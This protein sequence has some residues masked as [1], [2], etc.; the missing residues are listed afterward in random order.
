MVEQNC[1]AVDQGALD[2]AEISSIK[3]LM[4]RN[5]EL[6]KLYCTG[7]QY[8]MPCPNGVNIPR[9]FEIYNYDRVYGLADYARQQYAE[10]VSGQADAS[11]CIECGVCLDR[12][13]QH[14]E[15]PKQLQEVRERFGGQP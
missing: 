5:K 11:I 14:I 7:C 9:C 4:D 3:A 8:C 2:A 6:A 12:C 10:V 1:A 13:P 15:I